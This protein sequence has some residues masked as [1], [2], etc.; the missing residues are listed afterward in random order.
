MESQATFYRS[1]RKALDMTPGDKRA[2]A[3]RR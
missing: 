3:R 2:S 1:F